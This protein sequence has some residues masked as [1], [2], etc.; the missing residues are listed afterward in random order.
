MAG[1]T[2]G[3]GIGLAGRDGEFI[4]RLALGTKILQLDLKTLVLTR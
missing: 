4:L 2:Y 3:A 1:L